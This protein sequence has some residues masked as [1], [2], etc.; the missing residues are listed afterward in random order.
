MVLPHHVLMK[1]RS[2]GRSRQRPGFFHLAVVELWLNGQAILATNRLTK[3][4]PLLPIL[5]G[6]SLWAV[7]RLSLDKMAYLVGLAGLAL[8]LFP[9]SVAPGHRG[10]LSGVGTAFLAVGCLA[11]LKSSFAS[12]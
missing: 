6:F 4:R 10:L 9:D 8:A 2:P 1:C 11:I 3:P 7:V 12:R 5:P